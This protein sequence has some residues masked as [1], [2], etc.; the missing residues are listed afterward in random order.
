MYLCIYMS[1]KRQKIFIVPDGGIGNRLRAIASGIYLAENT[2]RKAVVI[3]HPDPL[4]NASLTDLFIPEAIPAEI[5]SPS[6][7]SFRLFYEQP[8]KRNLFITRL[9]APLRFSRRYYDTVNLQ[10]Y[11]DNCHL[12]REETVRTK[13]DILIYSGQEFYDFPRSFF[14]EIFKVSDAVRHRA[15]K[16][17][18]N[19][20]KPEISIQIRR[21]DHTLSIGHSPLE[22]FMEI[23]DRVAP[24]PFYL[25]TDDETV[26]GLIARHAP[27]RVVMNP[28]P[29][30]RNTPQG[31]LDAVAELLVMSRTGTIY[32]S[33]ASSFPEIASWLG[34][35]PLKTVSTGL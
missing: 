4:C 29:A 5:I 35:V 18:G 22:A 1:H 27:G 34:D 24:S 2:G 15:D 6:Q 14:R 17:S 32:G 23:I 30:A 16:I 33:Y 8:R 12:L 19:G 26:K 28:S 3:W 31:I 20:I 25:A 13:G 9:T 21:T 7:C 11:L 10:P